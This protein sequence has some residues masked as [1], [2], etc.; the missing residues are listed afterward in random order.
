MLLIVGRVLTIASISFLLLAYSNFG[1]NALTNPDI[2]P[3]LKNH[4]VREFVFGAFLALTTIYLVIRPIDLNRWKLIA[5]LGTIVVAPFWVAASFGFVTQ[6]MEG[7]W[8]GNMRGNAFV[9]HG[10]QVGGFYLGLLMLFVA[11]DR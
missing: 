11:R 7:V 10:S 6:G 4:L 3:Y 9:L 2:V 5:L 8:Q 1:P